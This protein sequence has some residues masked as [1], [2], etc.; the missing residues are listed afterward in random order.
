VCGAALT[1]GVERT[2]ERCSTCPSGMDEALFAR[3]V[4]WR[5]QQAQERSV[6]A[7][8]VFTD[9]TLM[10]LAE[11]R[12][13]TKQQLLRISGIGPQKLDLYGDELLAILGH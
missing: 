6:P 12:P 8:V 13:E 2:L 11:Q 4:E 7:Y 5:K 3:L 1:T 10:A 9:A